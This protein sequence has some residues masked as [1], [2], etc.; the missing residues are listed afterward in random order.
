[1]SRFTVPTIETARLILRPHTLEDA[2]AVFEWTSD[3][4]V[5]EFMNY[6]RHESVND[7]LEWLKSLDTLE[8]E[9]T[10]GIVRRQDGKLI[11]SCSIRR[12]PDGIFWSFGYNL[13]FD[14]WNQGYATEAAKCMIDFVRKEHNVGRIIAEHAV[15]NPASGRVMEKCGM[16]FVRFGEYSSFD[17]ARK[18]RSKVYEL[19]EGEEK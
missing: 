13:R 19:N 2:E 12:R 11:G 6:N 4:R 5:A 8:N 18:Y 3:E 1:M 10:W 7:S 14:C 17:G 15:D 16:H 9:Y